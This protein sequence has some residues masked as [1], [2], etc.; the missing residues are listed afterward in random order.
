MAPPATSRQTL[1]GQSRVL[2]VALGHVTRAFLLSLAVV[3]LGGGPSSP[4]VP[5]S[6][7]KFAS[8]SGFAAAAAAPADTAITA[9]EHATTKKQQQAEEEEEHGLYSWYDGRGS[10]AG[11]PLGLER[12]LAPSI[13]E[14]KLE[15]D[16]P[17]NFID[18][19]SELT[20]LLEGCTLPA[21][22]TSVRAKGDKP[23]TGNIVDNII[24]G[25]AMTW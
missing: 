5:A 2:R 9:A 14:D 6:S 19:G 24:D 13:A 3:V 21:K 1:Q 20:E 17:E 25:N 15:L 7:S 4:L 12:N 8:R 11:R 10:S 22:A 18:S 23:T 16:A